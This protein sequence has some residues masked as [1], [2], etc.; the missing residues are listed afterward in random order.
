MFQI[1]NNG[2]EEAII[3]IDDDGLIH[4]IPRE[5][6]NTDYQ[7]FLAWLEAGNTPTEYEL[8]TT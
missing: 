5:P 6:E 8:P 7:L 4:G 1:Y 2:I 3:R